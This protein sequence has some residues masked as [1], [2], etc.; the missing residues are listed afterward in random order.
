MTA[1]K[2][3]WE[4]KPTIRGKVIDALRNTLG[5][6]FPVVDRLSG[7]TLISTKSLD[8]Y[9]KSYQ[10]PSKLR[11]T[12]NKYLNDLINFETK[13]FKGADEITRGGTTLNLN[14]YNKKVLEVVLPDGI[15]STQIKEVFTNFKNDA[16][17]KGIEVW[18]IIGT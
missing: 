3:L 9:A 6:T 16:L 2:S 1:M 18:F 13:Y 15:I 4:L 8:T 17:A 11:G 7:T 14:Q 5:E 10:T 12:L